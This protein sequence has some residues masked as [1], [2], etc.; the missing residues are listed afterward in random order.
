MTRR[1]IGFIVCLA[2][3]FS[4]VSPGWPVPS[5]DATP[6]KTTRRIVMVLWRGMTPAEEGFI[7]Y[8]RRKAAPVEFTVLDCA[9]DQARLSGLVDRVRREK[10]DLIYAFGTTITQALAGKNEEADS[11]GYIR[12]IPIVFNIVAFPAK[13]SLLGAGESSG[14]NLT[15][16]SHLAPIATQV[17]AMRSV[18]AFERL[19]VIYNPGEVNST[20]ALEDL[21]AQ[22]SKFGF[23]LLEAPMHMRGDGKGFVESIPETV[24]SLAAGNPQ[25]IYIPSDSSLIS[26]AGSI[27]EAINRHRIPTF[28]AT[29]E[30]I[31]SGGA[32]M[33][34]VSQ[35]R[36][37]GQFAA[38][39]AEQIL[40]NG[41][42]PRDIPVE[43]LK[44][45]SFLVNM[46][47]ARRIG[48]YPPIKVF[49]FA[50]IIEP[51]T[52]APMTP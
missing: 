46:K 7:K 34:L 25:M 16:A 43:T 24:D 40:F 41:K 31:V 47:T 27:V 49:K 29:E 32:M 4:A 18:I 38:Y 15:G 10:P 51:Q 2:A 3:F 48:F 44:K 30:P 37:V 26:Q 45:F 1:S 8:F 39:K 52:V 42:A 14:R 9:G 36:S 5:E 28:S 13:A 35:Y 23:A 12:D 50:E 6:A 33:G 20:C 11:T 22:A 17:S 21:E 19:G